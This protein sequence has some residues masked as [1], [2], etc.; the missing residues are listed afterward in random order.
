MN[1]EDVNF[2]E[3]KPE[4]P[5]PARPRKRRRGLFLLL[6]VIIIFVSGCIARSIYQGQNYNDPTIYDPVTLEPKKPEGIFTRLKHFIF[7]KDVKLEGQ[8]SDRI[9]ILLLGMGGVGHDGPFLTDTII[10]A[11]IKPSTGEVAMIS[12][13]RDLGVDIPGFGWGKINHANS[14]GEVKKTNWGAAFATEVVEDTFNIDINYYTRVDFKAFEEIVDEVGGV[15][16]NVERTFSDYQYPA[17]NDEYR[18]VSFSKGEQSMN[19]SRALI[20]A[21]SRH[22][23]NGEGSDFAR[24][25]RQQKVLLALKEKI[26]SVRTLA[27]PVHIHN[28]IKSLDKHLTTNMSFSD[29]IAL[30]KMA[31]ELDTGNIITLVL[32]NGV[33]G[34]LENSHSSS[35][36][37]ILRPKTG[38]FDEINQA[39]EN[40]FEDG[41]VKENDTPE[42][43][44]EGIK[45]VDANIEIKNGTWRA[46]LAARIKEKLVQQ[47]FTITTIGN[48]KKRPQ[49]QSGIYNYSDEPYSNI[50]QALQEELNMPI[51]QATTTFSFAT[52]TDILVVLGEDYQE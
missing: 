26:F 51:K 15:N 8:R 43:S 34:Y 7:S 35:G 4:Q 42:Q 49:M 30:V 47:K 50:L 6:T 45:Y 20:Y 27:N 29:I 10:I 12:I 48:T 5:K 31:R 9:N 24:A 17:P 38:N 36:A 2:V 16:V 44:I 21:R 40:I 18:T 41:P 1:R 22:G 39:I 11:S 19:G 37:F 32:D 3:G 33:D 46:G 28:I 52:G 23:N 25:R 13:P 14:I